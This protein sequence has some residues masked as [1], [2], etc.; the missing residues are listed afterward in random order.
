M[1]RREGGKNGRWKTD[2]QK[3]GNEGQREAKGKER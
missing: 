2:W 1:E 3:R